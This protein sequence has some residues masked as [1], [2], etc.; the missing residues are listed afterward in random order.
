MLGGRVM[1]YGCV[2]AGCWGDINPT[3]GRMTHFLCCVIQP[4][5]FSST[6]STRQ[7][8][9]Q[10][11]GRAAEV[12]WSLGQIL[13]E[14]VAD[15]F[16]RERLYF[17]SGC[18]KTRQQQQKKKARVFSP[19]SGFI[20]LSAAHVSVWLWLTVFTTAVGGGMTSTVCILSNFKI[21]QAEHRNNWALHESLTSKVTFGRSETRC[22]QTFSNSDNFHFSHRRKKR[23]R[24]VFT[25]RLKS[26]SLICFSYPEPPKY[27]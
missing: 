22:I 12:T 15:S 14:G 2:E 20:W 25:P 17:F 9:E 5:S 7:S 16:L 8:E 3:K 10:P 6:V 26:D 11:R 1:S 13:Q 27:A 21:F 18:V 24:V 23:E 19:P 4:F